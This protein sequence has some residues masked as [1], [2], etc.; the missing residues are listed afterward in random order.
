MRPGERVVLV[1]NHYKSKQ[2]LQ[3]TQSGLQTL[4]SPAL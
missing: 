2:W 4:C 3:G 1:E